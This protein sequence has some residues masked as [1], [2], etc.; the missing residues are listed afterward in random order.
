[1][2]ETL[3]SYWNTDVDLTTLEPNRNHLAPNLNG[4]DCQV[5]KIEQTA[6]VRDFEALSYTMM[7]C[8]LANVLAAVF[9]F[10]TA[11]KVV[12]DKK[13]V[14]QAA[15]LDDDPKNQTSLLQ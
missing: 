15:R 8:V 5:S 1:L 2:T 9:F 12:R 13:R 10:A 7:V 6:A 3:K 11:F 14:E 4:T